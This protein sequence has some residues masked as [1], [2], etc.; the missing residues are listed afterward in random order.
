MSTTTLDF[1]ADKRLLIPATFEFTKAGGDTFLEIP[2]FFA[3]VITYI[4]IEGIGLGG[5]KKGKV[6]ILN[7][8]NSREVFKDPK[9]DDPNILLDWYTF[10][11]RIPVNGNYKIRLE[12][13]PD[14][15]YKGLIML[16]VRVQRV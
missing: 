10:E 1:P 13:I 4:A 12:D 2:F 14:G 3:G 7:V 15:L 8:D 11:M 16:E 6:R 5:N 9:P